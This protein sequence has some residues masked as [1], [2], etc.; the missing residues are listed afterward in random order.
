MNTVES[1]FAPEK[2]ELYLS[3]ILS[4]FLNGAGLSLMCFIS[5]YFTANAELLQMLAMFKG[6][7]QCIYI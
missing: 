1:S 7:C 5:L 6:L 2:D 3:K 4:L